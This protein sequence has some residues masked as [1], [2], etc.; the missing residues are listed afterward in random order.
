MTISKHPYK[1]EICTYTDG[2]ISSDGNVRTSIL[3]IECD[4]QRILENKENYNYTHTIWWWNT[5]TLR[6]MNKDYTWTSFI[7]E[8]GASIVKEGMFITSTVDGKVVN[9]EIRLFNLSQLG[10]MLGI[11]TNSIIV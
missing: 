11:D 6:Y 1:I 8:N 7:E 3:T 9:G 2:G 4:I 5:A 10:V